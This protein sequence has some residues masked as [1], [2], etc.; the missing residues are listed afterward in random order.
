MAWTQYTWMIGELFDLAQAQPGC[1]RLHSAQ[2]G[3]DRNLV[4]VPGS[5]Y[6]VHVSLYKMVC[7]LLMHVLRAEQQPVCR[8]VL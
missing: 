6:A 7:D 3:G 2:R 5:Q 1:S 8:S 4:S